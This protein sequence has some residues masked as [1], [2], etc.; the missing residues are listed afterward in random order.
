[1]TLAITQEDT[2]GD[3]MISWLSHPGVCHDHMMMFQVVSLHD[4]VAALREK[5]EQCQHIRAELVTAR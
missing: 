5:L 1:M 2:Y 3:V 4:S